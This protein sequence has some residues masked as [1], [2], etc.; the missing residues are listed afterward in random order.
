M[1]TCLDDRGSPIDGTITARLQTLN[2]LAR[3]LPLIGLSP[4]V[5]RR[6]AAHSSP[7]SCLWRVIGLRALC[8]PTG[9]GWCGVE[10]LVRTSSPS[11]AR[12]YP[13]QHGEEQRC[14]LCAGSGPRVQPLLRLGVCLASRRKRGNLLPACSQ[15]CKVSTLDAR[16]PFPR[17]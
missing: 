1:R 4:A 2:R 11:R 5:P 13:S 15:D 14:A 8:G 9:C 12:R 16:E 17:N 6:T 10:A 3:A 7:L